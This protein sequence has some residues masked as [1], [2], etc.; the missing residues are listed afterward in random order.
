MKNYKSLLEEINTTIHGNLEEGVFGDIFSTVKLSNAVAKVIS[1]NPIFNPKN[2]QKSIDPKNLE[3]V[4]VELKK[5]L[6][7]I[8]KIIE[9]SKLSP[10]LKEA[11]KQSFLGGVFKQLKELFPNLPNLEM[12]DQLEI[13]DEIYSIMISSYTGQQMKKFKKSLNKLWSSYDFVVMYLEVTY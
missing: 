3:S 4:K 2:K 7:E 9:Q 8:F 13:P 11:Y 10:N 5:F 6:N 12:K 1:K